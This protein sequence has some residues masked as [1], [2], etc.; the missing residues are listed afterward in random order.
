VTIHLIRQRT[1]DFDAANLWPLR[2]VYSPSAPTWV[3]AE[4]VTRWL[5]SDDYLGFRR[6]QASDTIVPLKAV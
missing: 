6:D 4:E 2:G 1:V 5:G 3:V